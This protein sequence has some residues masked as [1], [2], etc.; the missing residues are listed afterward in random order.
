MPETAT[1]K[2]AAQL[3]GVVEI[4]TQ[5]RDRL[6]HVA[7]ELFY[8]HGINPIGLD[9]I[10]N[11]AGVSK[12]TFYKHF[13][14]KDQLVLACLE[15]SAV[16]E[17]A[18]WGAAVKQIAGDNPRRQLL[19][20]VDVLDRWFNDPQ[21]GGC[22]FIN[23]AAEFP[24]PHDPVHQVAARHKRQARDWFRSMAHEAGA[25]DPDTFADTYTMLFE[26]ILVLR[27]IHDRTDA[28]QLGRAVIEKLVDEQIPK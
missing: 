10:L 4:P 12:T 16:W 27:Q 18:A 6:V 20:L 24:N 9:R 7:L 3:L 22:H 21:F 23:A 15:M 26:G 25:P 19:A 28:A 14:S 17:S 13:E 8:R 5:G 1:V 2:T 11:E